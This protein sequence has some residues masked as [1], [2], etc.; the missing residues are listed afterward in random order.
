MS[1]N[2]PVKIPLSRVYMSGEIKKSVCRVLDGGQYILDRECGKFEEE[3]ADFIGT[4]YA[5]AVGTGTAAIWLSLMALKV[6]PG[7]EIIV[8]S[9]TAF[10][11]IE[12]IIYIGA[13]PVFVDIDDTYTIDPLKIEKKITK[14]TVGI[15]PVHLYGHPANTGE[16]LQLARKHNLFVLEDCCQ[17]HGAEFK[18]KKVGAMG[19]AGC[20]S[21]YPSKNL[22]VCGDGG[23]VVTND[24][25]MDEKIRLLRDHG[26]ISRY[27]HGILGYNE[28]FNEIQA[29]IGRAQLKKLNSFN[30]RRRR[31]AAIYTDNLS[32]LDIIL[33]R[34]MDWAHH[35]FHMFVIRTKN[36]DKLAAFL[37]KHGIGTGIHY[38]VP[39]HLQPALLKIYGRSELPITEKYCKEI[40]SLPMSPSLSDADVKFVCGKIKKALKI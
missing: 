40:L 37:L 23:M 3:F 28:R 25:R 15:I 32:G 10:P 31:L 24:K 34:Q 22:T 36:R 4:K 27:V 38:P 30:A 19:I 9:L 39:C 26:R 2:L 6:K 20:F 21:F 18:G 16:I 17:A 33:P 11:T 5:I 12:P 1:A 8:T 7:D 29:A 35:V 13:K 14:K